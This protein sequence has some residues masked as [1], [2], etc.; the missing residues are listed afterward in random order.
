MLWTRS[1]VFYLGSSVYA[2]SLMLLLFLAGIAIGSLAAA[3]VVDRV[4]RPVVLLFRLELLLA[5]HS[6]LDLALRDPRRPAHRAL[7]GARAAP[8]VSP[9]WRSSRRSLPSSCRRPC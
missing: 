6:G 3:R 2:F 9:W 4:E 7:R 1:L 5:A 8:S